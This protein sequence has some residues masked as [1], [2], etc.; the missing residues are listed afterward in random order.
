MRL[1]GPPYTL[2]LDMQKSER[3]LQLPV[4]TMRTDLNGW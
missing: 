1:S 4:A 2:Q 3:A